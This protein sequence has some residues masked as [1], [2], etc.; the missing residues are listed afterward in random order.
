MLNKLSEKIDVLIASDRDDIR[1]FITKEHHYFCYEKGWIDNFSLE[2]LENQYSHYV[3]EG[4]NSFI[5]AFMEELRRLPKQNPK[6]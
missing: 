4:G 3:D 6:I 1:S 2:C 5:K